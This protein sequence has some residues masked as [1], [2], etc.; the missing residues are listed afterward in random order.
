MSKRKKSNKTQ[1]GKRSLTTKSVTN[2]KKNQKNTKKKKEQP[3]SPQKPTRK[4]NQNQN[5]NKNKNKKQRQKKKQK[6]NNQNGKFKRN[7]KQEKKIIKKNQTNKHSH[8]TIL[9]SK[10]IDFKTNT[11]KSSSKTIIDCLEKLF[12]NTNDYKLHMKTFHQYIEFPFN[13]LKKEQYEPIIQL[14]KLFSQEELSTYF[15]SLITENFTLLSNTTS[16][17][18]MFLIKSI[19][20][21]EPQFIIEKKERTKIKMK[22]FNMDN[23]NNDALFKDYFWIIGQGIFLNPIES[24]KV[25]IEE[26]YSL[27]YEKECTEERAN[28][29]F[30]FLELLLFYNKNFE[31][32]RSSPEIRI[33]PHTFQDYFLLYGYLIEKYNRFSEIKSKLTSQ[34]LKKEENEAETENETETEN[35]KYFNENE[36]IIN[37]EVHIQN[38]IEIEIE[39]EKEN[40]E[41]INKNDEK[42]NIQYSKAFTAKIRNR[43]EKTIVLIERL[44]IFFDPACTPHLYFPNILSLTTST[45][46]FIRNKA[47]KYL[48][49]S[50]IQDHSCFLVWEK[51]YTH[52]IPQSNNLLLFLLMN[53]N[54]LKIRPSF[55]S[56]KKSLKNFQN[57]NNQ[58]SHKLDHNEDFNQ[59]IN[60]AKKLEIHI[61]YLTLSAFQSRIEN[62]KKSKLFLLFIFLIILLFIFI[63]IFKLDV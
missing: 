27:L 16:L 33:K 13:Y 45:N 57:I 3:K 63:L 59:G 55:K 35:D 42:A 24:F 46:N 21:I 50:L 51:I 61:S 4:T 47:N 28:M 36:I 22:L 31:K 12:P 11:L 19:L 54:S 9:F 39:I 62:Q 15:L 49:R 32:L 6:Q 18:K 41:K 34:N 52:N 56:I 23:N 7:Q 20:I 43:I 26:Y 1:K 8:D 14:L 48:V 58:I 44:S 37:H 38:E 10:L 5:K 53:W 60:D 2:T 25:W 29:I 17:Q 30:D 40:L